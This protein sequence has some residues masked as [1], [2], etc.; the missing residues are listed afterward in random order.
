MYIIWKKNDL[1]RGSASSLPTLLNQ[2]HGKRGEL[3]VAAAGKNGPSALIIDIIKFLRPLASRWSACRSGENIGRARQHDEAW[4]KRGTKMICTAFKKIFY[5]GD[6]NQYSGATSFKIFP[7]QT[8]M[9]F[10]PANAYQA[11]LAAAEHLAHKRNYSAS[12][13]V[14]FWGHF[15][16]SEFW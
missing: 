7:I 6:A 5:D 3:N 8:C 1:Q 12:R 16:F 15:G 11:R 4:C 14:G 10:H 2:T 13:T 9:D